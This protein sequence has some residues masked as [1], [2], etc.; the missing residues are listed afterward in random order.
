MLSEENVVDLVSVIIP[1]YNEEEFIEECL[2]GIVN[3]VYPANKLEIIIADGMSTDNTRAIISKISS[4]YSFVRLVDN[5]VRFKPHAL[6]VAIKEAKGN[7]IIRCD[8]HSIYPP[9]YIPKLVDYLI[10]SGVDNVGG[11]LHYTPREDT[12]IGHSIIH[13]MTHPFGCGDAK[14]RGGAEEP[15]L[16]DTVFGGC[17]RRDVFER[18]GLFDE[19]L[20]RGQDREFNERLR[21]NG[22]RIKL[23][24][25][26]EC[27]YFSRSSLMGYIKHTYVSGI[28]PI[29]ISRI[30]KERNLG[31]RN[32]VPACFVLALLGSGV[33]S[34]WFLWLSIGF[35]FILGLH[36][37]GGILSGISVARKEGRLSFVLSMPLFF[38]LTHLAYGTGSLVGLIKPIRQG[39][40][41]TKI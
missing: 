30:T 23:F 40:E 4:E 31:L 21:R 29:Y 25:D 17:Y 1:C 5:P 36:L 33:L 8:A 12:L 13:A 6:N 15:M 10:E 26:V 19:R 41:W 32:F 34:I 7:I 22:G 24:P 9:D 18:I 16:V 11:I 39:E 3:S 35:L 37:F 14:H 27:T 28:T 2:L 38:L 20:L